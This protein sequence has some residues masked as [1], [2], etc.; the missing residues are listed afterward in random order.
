MRMGAKRQEVL[1]RAQAK[2]YEDPGWY[3]HP[4]GTVATVGTK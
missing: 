3:D 2:S 1:R 4:A